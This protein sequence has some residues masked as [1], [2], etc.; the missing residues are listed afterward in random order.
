[1]SLL[2]H[3][4]DHEV[5][6][7]AAVRWSFVTSANGAHFSKSRFFD[8][9]VD[10]IR[11]Y[12]SHHFSFGQVVF[13]GLC[14]L[15]CPAVEVRK[16]AFNLLAE[17]HRQHDGQ[18]SLAQFEAAI[19]SMAPSVYLHAQRQ[20]S[21]LLAAEHTSQ[22]AAIL[23][24]C[25]MRLPQVYDN[26]GHSMHERIL[27]FLEPWMSTI[28]LMPEGYSQLSP[29]GYRSLCNLFSLTVSYVDRYP[30]HIQALWGRLVDQQY[31]MNSSAT[32]KFLIEQAIRRASTKF[33]TYA[34]RVISCLSR[35]PVG[36]RTFE[37]LCSL[38]DPAG[39]SQ[40][41]EQETNFPEDIGRHYRADLGSL[42]PPEQPRPTLG[43]GE[44]AMLFLVDTAL[45]R[46][47]DLRP[48]LSGFLHALFTHFD[49]RLPF[50]EQLSRRM[51]FSQ[52]RAWVPGYDELPERHKY[53]SCAV[54]KATIDQ[55]EADPSLIFW[56]EN[57]TSQS[58]RGKLTRLCI[59][60]LSLLEPLHS[61]LRQEWGEAALVWGTSCASRPI[62]V[63][64]LQLLRVLIPKVNRNTLAGLLGRLSNTIADPDES[65]QSFTNEL[66]LTLTALARSQELDAAILPQYFWS[67]YACLSTSVEQE[68]S[69]ALEIMDALLDKLDLNDA[70]V[71]SDLLERKPGN[72]AGQAH[73]LQRLVIV[74]LKSS[75]TSA[76]S[77]K[78]L[79]R[80]AEYDNN[81]L[82]EPGDGRLRDLFT[83]S[84]PWCLD[85][86][87]TGTSSPGSPPPHMIALGEKIARLAE[88]A[89]LPNLARIMISFAKSRFRTKD[90]FLRQSAACL[91]E[92]FAPKHWQEVA[93]HLLS[94]VLNSQ[95][96]LRLKSMQVLQ[97]LFSHRESRQPLELFGS[98]LL[99]PLL[100][101]LQTDL[102]S[103]ALEVLDEQVTIGGG[104]PKPSQV[105]L[106]ISLLI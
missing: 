95:R 85:A 12:S 10:V 71:V 5:L 49:H 103:Q 13:L 25:A 57:D 84:L 44:L 55:L 70:A 41:T 33:I 21:D 24:Q 31:P 50:V 69:Q 105:C 52:L 102:A 7:D 90:D 19:G 11:T 17:L 104:G 59:E 58:S 97:G 93:T 16:T 62:A 74:G 86:M 101:L 77:F 23:A 18:L 45:E 4:Y 56:T 96:W 91:R 68:Y 87:D 92:Y 80:L 65:I 79:C 46:S 66:L 28:E 54:L 73:G 9:V 63:R 6:T 2:R 14:N 100:R 81:K 89:G 1:M 51:L 32:I 47:W 60:T 94:L 29:E 34:G 8:V 67:A 20:L 82:L 43:T 27:Q 48:Q 106:S 42:L 61:Q 26:M 99:M 35:T 15:S 38:I 30:D 83:V 64:S 75:V 98:E 3:P 39:M 37:D 22:G 72:W 40:G 88:T 53:P 76:A 36:K 78:I